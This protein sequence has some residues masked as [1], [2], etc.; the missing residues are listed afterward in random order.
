MN[1]KA[2]KAKVKALAKAVERFLIDEDIK[3]RKEVNENH[4][5]FF[6][7]R[8]KTIVCITTQGRI[9]MQ[10]KPN[11]VMVR[12]ISEEFPRECIKGCTD[13]LSQ[14]ELLQVAYTALKDSWGF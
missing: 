8:N 6:R 11:D 9:Y 14:E 10:G 12:M 7:L 4:T 3:Y 5:I 13:Y 2:K 1:K